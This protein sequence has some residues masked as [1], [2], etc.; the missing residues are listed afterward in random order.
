MN[1]LNFP[2][3]YFKKCFKKSLNLHLGKDTPKIQLLA[4][5]TG[6][7][8][9][10]R[11]EIYFDW[12][13]LKVTFWILYYVLVLSNFSNSLTYEFFISPSTATFY[14]QILRCYNQ[15]AQRTLTSYRHFLSK[16][17]SAHHLTSLN[18]SYNNIWSEG[19]TASF[20]W[21]LWGSGT[22]SAQGLQAVTVFALG[23]LPLSLS[24]KRFGVCNTFSLPSKVTNVIRGC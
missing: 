7:W 19:N 2:L 23:T 9:L 13:S 15:L 5:C 6:S 4:V 24:Q 16:S 18:L 21:M 10:D 22:I 12:V 17:L 20:T 1:L 14:C 8:G 3:K 11:R